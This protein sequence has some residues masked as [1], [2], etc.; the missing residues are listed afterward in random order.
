MADWS[1]QIN[2]EW[3]KLAKHLKKFNS[4]T[5][6]GNFLPIEY[7]RPAVYKKLCSKGLYPIKITVT[8][9]ND[10]RIGLGEHLIYMIDEMG[11]YIGTTDKPSDE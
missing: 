11:N 5:D 2:G 1:F 10:N 9:D 6:F 3:S 7:M 8:Q 4:T